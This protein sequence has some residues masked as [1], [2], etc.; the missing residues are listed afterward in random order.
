MTDL[1]D[2]VRPVWVDAVLLA[3]AGLCLIGMVSLG[4][5]QVDRM[6]GKRD[7]ITQVNAYAFGDPIPADLGTEMPEYQRVTLTGMYN[8]DSSLRI[9]AVTDLGP[10]SWLMTVFDTAAGSVWINRGFLP[11]GENPSNW[12]SPM[13]IVRVTGLVRHSQPGGT[14]LERNRPEDDRWV[15]ADL[16]VM[17]EAHNLDPAAPYFI[18]AEHSGR[19]EAWPRGG[20]TRI[21]FRDKHLSYALTWYAMAALFLVAIMYIVWDRRRGGS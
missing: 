4:N 6:A 11:T 8:H 5:W 12:T 10:G 3:L 14:L 1:P 7:L 9:K 20:M 13:G 2:Q 18:D 16:V 21:D 19:P 15:S 17:S